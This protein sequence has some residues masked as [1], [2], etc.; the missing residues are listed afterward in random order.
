MLIKNTSKKVFHLESGDCGPGQE[1]NATYKEFKMLSLQGMCVLVVAKEEPTEESTELDALKLEASE[2]GI[3]Y[4]PMCHIDVLR[5]R[6]E[7]FK[8]E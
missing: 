8:G 5:K 1:A 7:E 3:K 4:H 2:L 6:I